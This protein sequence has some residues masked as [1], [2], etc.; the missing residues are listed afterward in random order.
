[1]VSVLTRIFRLKKRNNL[2]LLVTSLISMTLL[3]FL[4]QQNRISKSIKLKAEVLS[5]LDRQN[6]NLHR[7]LKKIISP[8]GRLERNEVKDYPYHGHYILTNNMAPSNDPS[9][10]K[11]HE[12]V[13][14][15]VTS[16]SVTHN[17]LGN[18]TCLE[19]VRRTGNPPYFLTVVL[20]VRIYEKDKAKLT[21]K[22]LKMWLQYLRYA[23]V[24]HVYIY[25]AWVYQNESQLEELK[26]YQEDGYITYID[27]HTHNPYTIA[28]TQVAAYQHCIDHYSTETEWQ[29]AIDI[30]EY[31]FSPVDTSPGFLYRYLKHYSKFHQMVSELTMQN[32]LF[33]G[34]PHDK[35]LMIERLPRRTHNPSNPLVKPIYKPK[36]VRAQVHHNNLRNGR[37]QDAPTKELRMNHY[38]GAR[39]QNWGEDTPDILK[40]TQVDNGMDPIISAFK[41]CEK[42]VRPYL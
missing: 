2:L 15:N 18:E 20:L 9:I 32:F 21:T 19:W 39:L 22:E 41:N 37:S 4:Y 36:N 33:L 28:G 35:E 42:Y 11:G 27:W 24:E 6:Q 25:D 17:P 14:A 30:D 31:P 23:G 5:K 10:H 29:A 12:D 13:M 3:F 16:L 7:N 8:E 34:K 1:M 38:W 40:K 26:P